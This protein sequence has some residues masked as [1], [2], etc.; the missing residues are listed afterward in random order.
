M[1][2]VHRTILAPASRVEECRTLAA[3]FP[4]GVG[5]F[6]V[7]VYTACTDTVAYYISTGKIDKVL[8]RWTG[9]VTQF[10]KLLN[11]QEVY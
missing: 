6:K 9:A 2:E 1:T 10:L 5:M 11:K 3:S 7:P 8:V 4:R